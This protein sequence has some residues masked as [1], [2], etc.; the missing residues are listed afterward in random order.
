MADTLHLHF[1]CET[2]AHLCRNPFDSGLGLKACFSMYFFLSFLFLFVLLLSLLP[3][4]SMYSK[5]CGG[6]PQL[7]FISGELSIPA[8]TSS[9]RGRVLNFHGFFSALFGFLFVPAH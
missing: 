1:I 8:A 6:A 3:L 5:T 9:I 2:A 4:H 7:P